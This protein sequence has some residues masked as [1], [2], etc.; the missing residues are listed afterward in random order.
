MRRAGI[1]AMV[2]M[3][4]LI[5]TGC[6]HKLAEQPL[7]A[8]QLDWAR[9]MDAW[10]WKWKLPYHAPVRAAADN[11]P[12]V[13]STN[14]LLPSGGGPDPISTDAALPPLTPLPDL[15]SGGGVEDVVLVPMDDDGT[16]LSQDRVH[17]VRKG[18]TLSRISLKYYG[19]AT[20]WRRIYEANRSVIDSPDRL[21]VGLKLQIPPAE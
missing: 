14:D 6:R 16:T 21:D 19:K 2:F 8:Q 12:S 4:F 17:E 5:L 3:S 11:R 9:Q 13:P 15:P 10:Y 1:V 7:T 20:G 18:D